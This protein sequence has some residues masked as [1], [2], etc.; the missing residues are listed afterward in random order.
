MNCSLTGSS[1]GQVNKA[2][3]QLFSANNQQEDHLRLFHKLQKNK[4][5]ARCPCR[6]LVCRT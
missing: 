3:E 5:F 6:I 1:H 4:G 2:G